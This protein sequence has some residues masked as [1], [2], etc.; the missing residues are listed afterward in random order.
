MRGFDQWKRPPANPGL[1][2]G[3]S[4]SGSIAAT[5]LIVDDN[6]DNL[7]VMRSVLKGSEYSIV[8]AQTGVDALRL[9][10]RQ[11]FALIILDIRMPG[12]D[13]FE[14]AQ[15]IRT[16]EKMSRTPIIFLTAFDQDQAQVHRGYS[17]GAVDF[18]VKPIDPE[19]LHCK[20]S[21][22]AELYR[23]NKILKVQEEMLRNSK[24]ELEKRVRERTAELAR[25]NGELLLE[26]QEREKAEEALRASESRF[27]RVFESNIV[28]IFF[29][30]LSGRITAA[31][32]AFLEMLGYAH[33]D[34]VNGLH[35]AD[36]VPSE[37]R[38]SPE[39]A[40]ETLATEAVHAPRERSCVRKNGTVVNSLVGAAFMEGVEN[41]GL[42]LILDITE[43]KRAEGQLRQSLDE[44]VML[45]KE[46]HHRVKNNLQVISSILS[47]Q[48]DFISEPA[49]I[50]IFQEFQD[51]IYSIA[52]VHE[53]L[54]QT[55]HLASIDFGEYLRDLVNNLWRTYSTQ[56]TQVELNVEADVQWMDLDSAMHC[57]L[58]ATEL[59]T[60]AM[61]YA[62]P[63]G[64]KGRISVVLTGEEN[65]YTLMIK[66]NG[67]GLPE[68]FNYRSADSLGL[69]LVDIL[70]EQVDGKLTVES[71]GGT[72]VRLTFRE[73]A[74]AKEKVS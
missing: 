30:G 40:L 27:R 52:L 35:W 39:Y 11:E 26:I 72:E 24:D 41:K 23:K 22:F 58:I 55:E 16:R 66:D 34:L 3:E 42:S 57:G 21:V 2:E 60:N 1:A 33:E 59:L 14:T 65:E 54:Y 62:F 49:T 25:V 37:F 8:T 29:W 17:L 71:G 44:K 15:F 61:K 31:N 19:V 74:A 36:L 69:K 28:G 4:R 67:V 45:L 18:I 73:P 56:L 48:S 13:G 20:V 43:R 10:L 12:M 63:N 51:R 32:D 5:I 53:L 64:G 70:A 38:G 46:I 50:E 47:L 68:N 6:P 9:L 7:S